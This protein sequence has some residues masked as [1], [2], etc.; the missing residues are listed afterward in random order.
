MSMA[1]STNKAEYMAMSECVKEAVY[2]IFL[3]ELGFEKFAI[4]TIYCDKQNAI[5]P[6][7]NSN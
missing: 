3:R 2:L 4:P 6:A 5:N 7:K 1:K